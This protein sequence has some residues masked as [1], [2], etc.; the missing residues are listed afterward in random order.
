MFGETGF[1]TENKSKKN[2]RHFGK[3]RGIVTNVKDT[4][5]NM[6]MIKA[7]VPSLLG[8]KSETNWALPCVPFAGTNENGKG[9]GMEFLPSPGD[10]VWM[11]FEKGDIDKPIWVGF[12]WRK[13]KTPHDNLGEEPNHKRNILWLPDGSYISFNS[14]EGEELIKFK[15]GLSNTKKEIDKSGN[16]TVIIDGNDSLEIKGDVTIQITGDADINADG[17]VNVDGSTINLAG[18]GSGVARVGDTIEV[19]IPSGSSAGTYKGHITEGSSV[20]TDGG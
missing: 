2:N 5:K 7:K 4:D 6:C 15:H 10:G 12:W 17:T 8:H 20:T 18:G 1:V 19:T 9:F 3:Y 16:R 14:T 13:G 11:E